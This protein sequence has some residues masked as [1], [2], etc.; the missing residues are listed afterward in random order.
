MFTGMFLRDES[1]CSS[2]P[3][4]GSL[5]WALEETPQWMQTS[6]HAS[7]TQTNQHGVNGVFDVVGCVFVFGRTCV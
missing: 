5:N 3:A 1:N 2:L 6:Q 4:A 7:A